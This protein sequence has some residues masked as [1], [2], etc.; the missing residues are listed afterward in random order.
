MGG[1]LTF[2][3]TRSVPIGT[4]LHLFTQRNLK[5]KILR[6]SCSQVLAAWD[7]LHTVLKPAEPSSVLFREKPRRDHSKA[8]GTWGREPG[9][10]NHGKGVFSLGCALGP[11]GFIR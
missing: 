7:H 10:F 6:A 4:G 5:S 2:A 8:L 1:T 9:G 3:A 11:R